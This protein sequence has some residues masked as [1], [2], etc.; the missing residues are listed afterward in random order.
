MRRAKLFC[1]SD[2]NLSLL[3]GLEGT[4]YYC[5][6]TVFFPSVPCFLV[7]VNS[8]N[9]LSGFLTAC[10][11]RLWIP[12]QRNGSRKPEVMCLW[13]QGWVLELGRGAACSGVG[14]IQPLW[15][16]TCSLFMWHWQV[17]AETD[18][19]EELRMLVDQRSKWNLWPRSLLPWPFVLFHL[20]WD[21]GAAQSGTELLGGV[22]CVC[23]N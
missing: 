16:S 12:Y 10:S 20:L 11:F 1:L 17:Q 7:L 8:Y 3:L 23:M 13:L 6:L 22:Q 5:F 14:L 21:A 15:L 2:S 18:M 9:I 19:E 4:C